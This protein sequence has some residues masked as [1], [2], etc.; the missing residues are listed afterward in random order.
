MSPVPVKDYDKDRDWGREMDREKQSNDARLPEIAQL[1]HEDLSILQGWVGWLRDERDRKETSIRNYLFGLI[2][3]ARWWRKP[4][5]QLTRD[6]AIQ[7]KKTVKDVSKNPRNHLAGPRIYL[8]YREFRDDEE[9]LDRRGELPEIAKGF[10]FYGAKNKQRVSIRD[11]DVLEVGEV[12]AIIEAARNLPFTD[13]GE[14]HAC[15]VA[16]LYASGFRQSEF[17]SMRVKD[18]YTKKNNGK[19]Q[20]WMHCPRSKVSPEGVRDVPVLWGARYAEI[21]LDHRKEADPDDALWVTRNNQR[22]VSLRPLRRVIRRCPKE[23]QDKF[24]RTRKL[25]HLF[26]HSRMTHLANEGRSA[27][28]LRDFGGWRTLDMPNYYVHKVDLGKESQEPEEIPEAEMVRC[29]CGYETFSTYSYCP[30]CGAS[31]SEKAAKQESRID[32]LSGQVT[33]VSGEVTVLREELARVREQMA[34]LTSGTSAR[35]SGEPVRFPARALTRKEHRNQS[36]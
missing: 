13:S 14:R 31:L 35:I 21:W 25:A 30:K 20:F 3:F 9:K 19:V 34:Q 23:V 11:M 12:E 29:E 7:Y 16:L 22:V 5:D 18:L 28:W 15:Q 24:A 10:S 33:L 1:L 32:G 26:R 27:F 4:L 36:E 6:D 8:K 17:L 2:R